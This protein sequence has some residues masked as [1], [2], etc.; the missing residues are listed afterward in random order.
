MFRQIAA[1]LRPGGYLVNADIAS[2]ISTSA[3]KSLF[4][5]WMQALKYSEMP[6]EQV[7]KFRTS[8]GQ[9]VAVLPPHEVESIIASCGFD[10]P[11]L[12]LQ[13]LFIHA[14]YCRLAS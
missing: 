11:V 1:R 8:F 12:F 4:D 3:H 13:S 10:S 9:E 7:E 2:D 6:D 5:V 14:W